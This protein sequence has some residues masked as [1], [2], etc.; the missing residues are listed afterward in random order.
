[1]LRYSRSTTVSKMQRT[2]LC[3]FLAWIFAISLCFLFCCFL[4]RFSIMYPNRMY[5]YIHFLFPFF[6]LAIHSF[7]LC[8]FYSMARTSLQRIVP[9]ISSKRSIK[10]R[11]AP[12]TI[13]AEEQRLRPPRWAA[14]ATARPYRLKDP[15]CP[16][17]PLKPSWNTRTI[18]SS[19]HW[20]R[21]KHTTPLNR[22]MIFFSIFLFLD[23][24]CCS[25]RPFSR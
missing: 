13:R 12:T 14:Q 3:G 8:F 2:R 9:N 23:A 10:T 22:W 17:D 5:L 19:W 11:P 25:Y 16:W 18:V 4:F 24:R 1:M 15:I 21:G 7:T 20:P 6:F